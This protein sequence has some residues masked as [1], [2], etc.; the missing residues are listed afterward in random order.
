V[1]ELGPSYMNVGLTNCFEEN[2]VGLV[3]RTGLSNVSGRGD[4]AE[5]EYTRGVN[6]TRE[7]SLTFVR[8]IKGL[9]PG[10]KFFISFSKQ[11]YNLPFNIPLIQ[12]TKSLA[13][14]SEVKN[15]SVTLSC[16]LGLD[17]ANSIVNW[18]R[19][20]T[21]Q[22]AHRWSP[23]IE[24]A[25][26]QLIPSLKTGFCLNMLD[27]QLLPTHGIKLYL[28]HL[29]AMVPWTSDVNFHQIRSGI[30]AYYPFGKYISGGFAAMIS[31]TL[32]SS[33]NN[34]QVPVQIITDTRTP[35]VARG[36]SQTLSNYSG[37][38][39]SVLYKFS[40]TSKLPFLQPNSMLCKFTRFHTYLTGQYFR[41]QSA[42]LNR[43]LSGF[44][45][46]FGIGLVGTISDLGRFELNYNVPLKQ[47]LAKPALSF[48]FGTEF[49]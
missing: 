43:S 32:P 3:V 16:K 5:V 8:P 31:H 27:S 34:P 35:L 9:Q 18:S 13:V 15:G 29:L 36:A 6:S 39:T 25:G 37:D 14:G 48:G 49:L 26:C 33:L 10:S 22:G 12:G 30:S 24:H 44:S 4:R 20:T 40:L 41:E 7:T 23:I 19:L 38:L 47:G 11:N 1:T 21:I 2:E 45:H 46:Y 17:L 42:Q 28:T